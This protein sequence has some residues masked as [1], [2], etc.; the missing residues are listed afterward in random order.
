MITRANLRALAVR[1]NNEWTL[2][3]VEGFDDNIVP[4]LNPEDSLVEHMLHELGHAVLLGLEPGPD[5]AARVSKALKAGEHNEELF[6]ETNEMWTFA[7]VM[8]TLRRLGVRFTLVDMLSAAEV[9]CCYVEPKE[10]PTVWRLFRRTEAYEAAIQEV[11]HIISEQLHAPPRFVLHK[12]VVHVVS[13]AAGGMAYQDGTVGFVEAEEVDAL[14][15][16]GGNYL[17]YRLLFKCDGPGARYSLDKPKPNDA[18]PTC[19]PAT[20]LGCL[21]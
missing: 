17:F 2:N 18:V 16:K 20:C 7:V 19:G 15:E 8:G 11:I 4:F 3:S 9:Q 13:K 1:L 6:A 21:A 5:L 10:I 12:D 14:L